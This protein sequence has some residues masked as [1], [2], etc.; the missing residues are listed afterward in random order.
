MTTPRSL[1][2]ALALLLAGCG[3]GTH[4][5]ATTAAIPLASTPT[6][7]TPS[8][9]TST[10]TAARST[11]AGGPVPAGFDPIAFTAISPHQF[12]LLGTAPCPRPICT[13][14]VRTTDGGAHFVGI[15]APVARL[16]S[17]TGAGLSVLLF[18]D[19]QDGFAGS[20]QYPEPEPLWETHDGGAH[21]TRGRTDVIAFTVTAG[22]VYAHHRP[23]L[24]PRGLLAAAPHALAGIRRRLE[25]GPA[26]RRLGGR[27][28]RPWPRRAPRSGSRSPRPPGRRATRSC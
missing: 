3:A 20:A 22:Y 8:A 1:I 6:L 9:T 21:W 5:T 26:P 18:A 28:S 23:L 11:P 16:V 15:P 27:A 12:W 14:I 4:A 13:S 17:A 10:A 7:A 2:A 25:L 24:Q 19:R